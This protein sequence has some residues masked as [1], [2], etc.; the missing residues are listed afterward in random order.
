[1]FFVYREVSSVTG[2]LAT[3]AL[4]YLQRSLV[5]WA[6]VVGLL[7]VL[8]FALQFSET[9]SRRVLLTWAV[10]TPITIAALQYLTRVYISSRADFNRRAVIAGVSEVSRRLADKI[11]QHAGHGLELQGWF[12]DRSLERV[13]PI[14]GGSILGT[15]NDLPAYVQQNDIDVIYIALPIRHEERT[16]RLL[17]DLHD[18]TASIY[19]VPDIFVFDLIQS[20]VDSIDGVPVL[21]LCE[22]PFVGVNGLVKRMSD[23]LLALGIFIVA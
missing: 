4:V 3:R 8:G 16:Q 15:L 5:A 7:A 17:D 22:T 2:T 11:N 20:R 1:T 18:T 14:V 23:L 12:E 13:G 19:F 10:L 9:Y 6:I 21:A